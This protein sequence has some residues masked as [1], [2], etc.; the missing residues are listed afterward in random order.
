MSDAKRVPHVSC[1]DGGSWCLA[2]ISRFH[3]RL[4]KFGARQ[5]MLHMDALLLIYREDRHRSRNPDLDGGE[6]AHQRCRKRCPSAYS[7]DVRAAFSL[8]PASTVIQPII[9]IE[10][11]S[12]MHMCVDP[13]RHDR[14]AAQVVGRYSR[15]H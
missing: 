9:L 7:A 3:R 5:S 12:K 13:S 4:R 14:Q 1:P 6:A 10:V 15:G 8:L 11:P 2:G